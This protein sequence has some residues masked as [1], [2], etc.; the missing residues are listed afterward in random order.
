MQ[1]QNRLLIS[2]LLVGAFLLAAPEITGNKAS[3][4]DYWPG[5]WNWYDT[6]YR[7]Y[8]RNYYRYH[9]PYYGYGYSTPG[10]SYYRYPHNWRDHYRYHPHESYSV[11]PF[12]FERW[13]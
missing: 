11:G 13:H 3:G 4:D 9:R 1:F 8:Y 6:R 2:T 5:Y 10:F 12:R 7:P